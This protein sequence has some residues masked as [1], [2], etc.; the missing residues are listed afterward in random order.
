[1]SL[2]G[3][4]L[5][6]ETALT[7]RRRGGEAVLHINTEDDCPPMDFSYSC[8]TTEAETLPQSDPVL[9]VVSNYDP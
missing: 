9:L 5:F 1:M 3:T 8:S 7:S 6:T 4:T 2:E